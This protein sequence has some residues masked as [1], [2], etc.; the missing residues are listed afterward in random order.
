MTDDATR[1]GARLSRRRLLATAAAFPVAAATAALAARL[2]PARAQGKVSQEQ[3]QYQD[4]P[5]G[6]QQCA[7]CR[8]FVEG[9]K[10]QQVEGEISPSGWCALYR[11][12]S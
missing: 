2:T 6:D 9:N 11:P 12:K 4:E 5:K 3:A 1:L 8:Y 7:G 10:C